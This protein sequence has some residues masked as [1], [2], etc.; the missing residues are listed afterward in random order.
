M[1]SVNIL[2]T[3]VLAGFFYFMLKKLKISGNL[4][5]LT[6][7]FLFLPRFL[8]LRTTGAPE[9]LFLL[10]ILIS[11]FSFEKENYL[12]AGLFGALA[13]AT[14]LPGIILFAAY[15]AV[16][17][18]KLIVTR[19]IRFDWIWILLIPMGTALVFAWY[20]IK[21]G[22][23]FAF[24]HTGATVPMPY[25]F[26]AFN[27]QAKWV[28][29]AWLEDILFYFFFYAVAAYRLS[30]I[31]QRSFYYF[32]LLFLTASLFVE[33]RDISRYTLPLW[34][35]ALIAFERFFTSPQVRIIGA[36]MLIAVYLY[37]WNFLLYN[38]MPITQWLPFL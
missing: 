38:V 28:G 34:P 36:L 11:L 20:G 5:L 13:G 19:K 26:S 23:F 22:D 33:H 30:G 24:F 15:G 12:L 31:K 21:Y 10:F 1:I 27:S 4:L 25:P 32:S 37:A 18:E 8:V 2:A 17:I 6:I 14:K 7:I 3:A 16:F 35:L 29:T 9:S